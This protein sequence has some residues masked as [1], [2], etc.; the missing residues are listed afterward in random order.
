MGLAFASIDV[1]MDG[2]M[3]GLVASDTTNRLS[4]R[5]YVE[6]CRKKKTDGRCKGRGGKEMK[7][8]KKFLLVM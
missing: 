2:W 6:R 5:M 7:K 3:D 4:Q 8:E 1:D